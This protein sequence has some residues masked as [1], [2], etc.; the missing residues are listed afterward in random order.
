MSFGK[1]AAAA[2][3]IAPPKDV[4]LKD[5]KD[6]KLVGKPTK[7]LEVIDKV[8]ASRSTASTCALPD[9]LYAALVQ[10]PVFRGTLKSVDESQARR[11]EGRPQG[12][13]SSRTRSRS[14][15]IAGGRRRRPPTRWRSPGTRAATARCRARRSRISCAPASPRPTP[16]SAART[17]TSPTRPRAGGQAGRGRYY[18]PFLGHATMEPQ[19]CTA[20]VAA[21]QVEIWVPTQNA[22]SRARG[23]GAGGRRLAAQRHRAPD[24]ARRR[25]RPARRGA[26]LRPAGGADRQGDRPAGEDRLV[27]RRGHPPRLLPAGGDGADDRRARCRRHAGRLARAA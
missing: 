19:N 13:R 7:R 3:K 1:V 20:K 15:P 8:R 24:H 14:S 26:G 21:D 17:A 25:L 27:A 4:K 11:H 2:A 6:W 5:P 23:G 10:C 12:R 9:M 22:R 18:V 16:A